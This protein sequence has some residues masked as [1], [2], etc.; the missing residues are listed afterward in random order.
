MKAS[1]FLLSTTLVLLAGSLARSTSTEVPRKHYVTGR[2]FRASTDKPVSSVWVMALRD[3]KI[4]GKS[5]T[6]DSGRYY[7]SKLKEGRYTIE[8]R[9]GK[10]KL[11]RGSIVLPRDRYHDIRL[12]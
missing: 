10:E 7:I 12:P 8:V 2:V 9:K 1:L 5:L 3:G 6:G 11:Y 4:E